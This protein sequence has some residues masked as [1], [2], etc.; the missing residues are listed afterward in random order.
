MTK[1]DQLQ[2]NNHRCNRG[3][4]GEVFGGAKAHTEDKVYAETNGAKE[5]MY[6]LV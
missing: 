4:T 1:K 2:A 3:S 6:A 5:A